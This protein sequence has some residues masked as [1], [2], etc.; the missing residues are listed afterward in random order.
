MYQHIGDYSY[1]SVETLYR[2]DK[3]LRTIERRFNQF[4]L[5]T[6]EKT[7]QGNKVAQTSTLYGKML[8]GVPFDDQPRTFQLATQTSR[9]WYRKGNSPLRG[10]VI[11]STRYDGQGNVLEIT[12]ANGVKEINTWYP[13]EASPGHPKD[14][15]GFDRHL[16]ERRIIPA[17]N[18]GDTLVQRYTYVTRDALVTADYPDLQPCHLVDSETL[19]AVDAKGKETELEIVQHSYTDDLTDP[20]QH[21]RVSMRTT[22]RDANM[23]MSTFEYTHLDTLALV[24]TTETTMG[25]WDAQTATQVSL[26]STRTGLLHE[27]HDQDGIV[28]RYE[29][30]LLGRVTLESVTSADGEFPAERSYAYYLR[31]ATDNANAEPPGQELTDALGTITRTYVDGLG[32]PVRVARDKI[33]NEAPKRLHDTHAL[34]YDEWGNKASETRHDWYLGKQKSR[35]TRYQYDDW[36]QLTRTINPEGTSLHEEINPIGTVEHTTGAVIRRWTSGSDGQVASRVE[37]WMNLFDKPVRTQRMDSEWKALPGHARLQAYDGLGRCTKDTNERG[38]STVYTYDAYDRVTSTLLPDATLLEQ[39]YASHSTEALPISLTVTP[40]GKIAERKQIASQQFDSLQRLVSRT[41]GERTETYAFTGGRSQPDSYTTPAGATIKYDYDLALTLAPK[42]SLL[43]N[44]DFNFTYNPITGDL[45]EAS[46]TIDNES[47]KRSYGYNEVGQLTSETWTGPDGK[48][49]KTS[50][51]ISSTGLPHS[52]LQANNVETTYEYDDH[53]R[54]KSSTQGLVKV[55]YQY[56]TQGRPWKI[57]TED[58]ASGG[59]TQVTEI[60]YDDYGHENKRTETVAG[61]PTR[62]VT[63]LWGKDDLLDERTVKHGDDD[64]LHEVFSYDPAS[65]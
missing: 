56:D 12:K 3:P 21:G 20:F 49:W 33:D 32:R 30:D 24:Q 28:T 27:Q 17:G 44:D 7:T 6:L 64:M 34:S 19:V 59:A 45:L 38:Y 1:G 23:I 43:A 51:D 22:L 16:K 39:A 2:D 52:H 37:T 25:L 54:L 55:G 48:N 15:E 58:T 11:E 14:P 35:V 18:D 10:A 4:H 29:Y 57:T 40:E 9:L 5:Q 46:N 8:K 31:G 41:M 61:Q 53:L 42:T 62:I 13:A 63:Q 65:A 60:E 50:Q 47:G 36:G 26:E